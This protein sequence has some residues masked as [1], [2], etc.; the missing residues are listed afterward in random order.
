M[1]W[2]FLF[3][4]FCNVW[5][6]PYKIFLNMNQTN[7]CLFFILWYPLEVHLSPYILKL[8]MFL[9]EVCLSPCFLK[10]SIVTGP[11]WTSNGSLGVKAR[12]TSFSFFLKRFTLESSLILNKERSN[13]LNIVPTP[14]LTGNSIL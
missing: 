11:N 10:K 13:T 4:Y 14:Y 2:I 12:I 1:F 6:L 5:M 7:Q 3:Q 8:W 9:E